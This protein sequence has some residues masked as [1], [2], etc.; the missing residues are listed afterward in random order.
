MRRLR[1]YSDCTAMHK[2]YRK[3]SIITNNDLYARML[4]LKSLKAWL[5]KFVL[6][7]C[8]HSDTSIQNEV[9]QVSLCHS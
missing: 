1:R 2:S 5:K 8:D 6:P 3:T 4:P 9:K 7:F